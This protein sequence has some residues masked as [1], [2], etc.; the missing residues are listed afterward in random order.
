M[1]DP[2][3]K[4]RS[5]SDVS[6]ICGSVANPRVSPQP[7]V[8]IH[9]EVRTVEGLIKNPPPVDFFPSNSSGKPHIQPE[10]APAGTHTQIGA[11]QPNLAKFTQLRFQVLRTAEGSAERKGWKSAAV[12]VITGENVTFSRS[13]DRQR[14]CHPHGY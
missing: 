9:F 4:Q 10:H 5:G 1:D 11:R 2:N 6:Q 12:W 14:R 13:V 8:G 3:F 7:V